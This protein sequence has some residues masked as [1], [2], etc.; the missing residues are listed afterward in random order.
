MF[1]RQLW[2]KDCRKIYE[3]KQNRFFYEMFYSWCFAFFNEK[4]QNLTFG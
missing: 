1:L 4:R 3:I 2:E